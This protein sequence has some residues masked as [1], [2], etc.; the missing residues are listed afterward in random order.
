MMKQPHWELDPQEQEELL[1]LDSLAME[2]APRSIRRM[3]YRFLSQIQRCCQASADNRAYLYELAE[4]LHLSI[5]ALSRSIE[6]LQEKGYVLW[7]TDQEQ[8]RTYVQ[9]SSKAVELMHE[10]QRRLH[11]CYT[12]IHQEIGAEEL[13]SALRTLAQVQGILAQVRREMETEAAE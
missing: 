9:L 10:E 8:E 3:D 11:R 7:K 4:E 12:R 1:L 5:P 2:P 13:S 6:R